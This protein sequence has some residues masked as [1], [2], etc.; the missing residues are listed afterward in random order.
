M[1]SSLSYGDNTS[2]SQDGWSSVK[3]VAAFACVALGMGIPAPSAASVYNSI[4]LPKT[5]TSNYN[6]GSWVTTRSV[7]DSRDDSNFVNDA[8]LEMVGIQDML[9]CIKVSL[10]LSKKDEAALLG[11]SR[12]TLNAYLNGAEDSQT[13]NKNTLEKIR[14][15]YAIV[16][17]ISSLFMHSPGAMLKSYTL[18]GDSLFSL[19][20][21]ETLNE[22]KIKIIA[23]RLA[24]KISL[25]DRVI[26]EST[27]QDLTL[28]S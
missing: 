9:H 27:L 4:P 3:K 20:S 16:S 15:V 13:I 11:M 2:V 6:G 12:P 7:A 14:N 26:N 8:T 21:E 1:Y 22:E 24:H 19:L 17:D 23:D 10:G 5:S 28:S 25:P 18:E